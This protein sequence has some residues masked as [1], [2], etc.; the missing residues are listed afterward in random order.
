[1]TAA[2]TDQWGELSNVEAYPLGRETSQSFVFEDTCREIWFKT[3]Q[4]ASLVPI[5][6]RVVIVKNGAIDDDE[7]S[8]WI[9]LAEDRPSARVSQVYVVYVE[10]AGPVVVRGDASSVFPRHLL[11]TKAANVA[12]AGSPGSRLTPA[13]GTVESP[14]TYGS[15]LA[16]PGPTSQDE[17]RNDE[18]TSLVDIH[19]DTYG[20]V[21]RNWKRLNQASNHGKNSPLVSGL[22]VRPAL[23]AGEEHVQFEISMIH[24]PSPAMSMMKCLLPQYR[25]LASLGQYTGV[26]S[27]ESNLVPWHI[28]ASAKMLRFCLTHGLSLD[29]LTKSV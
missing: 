29:V 6:W 4:I 22:L 24:S 20:V 14:D 7:L 9:R 25:R 8:T 26:C 23:R 16:T 13:G 5:H 18:D 27:Q 10:R 17:S 11:E 1:V 15:S 28:E 2:W 12:P 3:L 19:D 21:Y